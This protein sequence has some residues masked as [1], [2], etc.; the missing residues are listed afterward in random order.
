MITLARRVFSRLKRLLRALWTRGLSDGLRAELTLWWTHQLFHRRIVRVRPDESF[1]LKR[2]VKTLIIYSRRHLDPFSDE[3]KHG[4]DLTGGPRVILA[5]LDWVGR[6]HVD[7]RCMTDPFQA[8][9]LGAGY[10]QII[11]INSPFTVAAMKAYP[12]ANNLYLA[13]N[14][15]IPYRNAVLY[16][17]AHQGGLRLSAME[18]ADASSE[19]AIIR[20]CST[21]MLLGNERGGQRF[22]ALY[23]RKPHVFSNV[24]ADFYTEPGAVER[25]YD[26]IYP[27]SY[28]CV[29][30]G[31][32]QLLQLLEL[33][34]QQAQPLSFV[35]VGGLDAHYQAQ[36]DRIRSDPHIHL[37]DWTTPD[38]LRALYQAS[39]F[40]FLWSHEEGQVSTVLE[41]LES[42]CIPFVSDECGFP[43]DDRLLQ[44]KATAPVDRVYRC[45]SALVYG[46]LERLRARSASYYQDH[47]VHQPSRFGG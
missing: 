29:R 1:K 27:T 22:M 28:L 38:E 43:E 36:Y 13:V 3:D 26:V 30:K 4:L 34:Q 18:L 14:Q 7:Y 39:T 24:V 20:A 17:L 9:D 21:I 42:G 8:L 31:L 5:I 37:V 33:N 32:I 2:Q 46:D 41:S 10:E 40:S 19:V 35:V 44:F 23:G 15:P 25:R 47:F 45:L 16:R 6:A 11:G 12:R